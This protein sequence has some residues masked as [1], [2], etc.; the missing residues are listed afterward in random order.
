M[1]D[2]EWPR[3]CA[4]HDYPIGTKRICVDTDYFETFNRDNVDLVDVR[5]TPI[6]RDHPDRHCAR[7]TAEYDLDVIV[8]ATGFDAMT[9]SLLGIDIRGR[10]GLRLKDKW[11][12]GPRTYLGLATAGFPNLFI[13]TGPGSPSVLTNMSSRSSS[14]S[15]GS[16]TA[17]VL[18]A[19]ARPRGDRGDRAGA[20]DALGRPRQRG[21]RRDPL[22]AA[23]SWYM[24]A[25]SVR[26]PPRNTVST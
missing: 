8:F 22:P 11:A 20:E 13:I 12:D 19:R 21:R 16:P 25:I 3:C 2:P 17:L 10:D 23:N 5:E 14:T 15:T 1:K 18:H 9:G 4:P 26:Y 24:G 6:E 7:P